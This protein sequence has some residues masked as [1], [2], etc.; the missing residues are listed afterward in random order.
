ME[1][2]EHINELCTILKGG[3]KDCYI[4]GGA[5]RDKLLNKE[6]NDI[7]ITTDATPEET[8]R[9]FKSK[10]CSIYPLGEKFGTI[11]VRCD[12]SEDYVEVTTY[13]E[14]G[15]YTDSR[16]PSEVKFVKDLEYDVKRRDFTVNALAYDPIENKLIDLV[17]G[18]KDLDRKIIRA[19]GN[20]D[21][22]FN[23]DAL[24]IIRG[25]RFKNKLGFEIEKET[26]ESMRRNRKKVRDLSGERVRDELVKIMTYDKPSI[27]LNCLMDSGVMEE[28]LPELAVLKGIEQPKEFHKYD[29]YGH[30]LAVI[31]NIPKTKPLERIAAVLHDTG[32]E[33]YKD[34]EI[35]RT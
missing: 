22:R 35:P 27:G 3:G 11:A 18:K 21:D 32:K 13:R 17:G 5:V 14:D 31:E 16:R 19:I 34:G 7:D 12:K 9:L 33:R 8:K 29:V 20:P 15:E 23:D 6:P 10:G 1:F 2:G 24:R 26:F 28:V 30:T 4:V 25:C